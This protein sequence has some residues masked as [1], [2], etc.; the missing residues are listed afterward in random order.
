MQVPETL[1]PERSS[2]RALGY[3]GFNL[4]QHSPTTRP[5]VERTVGSLS[6]KEG[7]KE[8]PLLGY[9]GGTL[10]PQPNL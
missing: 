2:R 9:Q 8:V 3:L 5:S 10:T 6:G 7:S 4:A 1:N